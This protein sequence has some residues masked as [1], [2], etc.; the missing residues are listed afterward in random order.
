MSLTVTIEFIN[1]QVD[2]DG[3]PDLTLSWDEGE[4]YYNFAVNGVSV[5]SRD[6]DHTYSAPSGFGNIALANSITIEIPGDRS[7]P[8]SNFT[9]SGWVREW[10]GSFRFDDDYAGEFS[11]RY[12]WNN[13]YGTKD[14]ALSGATREKI[15][16]H[17]LTGDGIDVTVFW[18]ISVTYS[19]AGS[20][21]ATQPGMIGVRAFV[22]SNFNRDTGGGFG[23]RTRAQNFNVGEYPQLQTLVVIGTKLRQGI[24]P[25]AISSVLVGNGFYAELY[26]Q[27]N[28]G[29]RKLEI[30][31]N[32]AVMPG[33]WNDKTQSLR[34]MKL[35]IPG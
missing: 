7:D 28:F 12:D 6:S 23:L 1:I 18:K 13:E 27:P 26:D 25:N 21:K 33:D 31:Q 14:G 3:D 10:D 5:S 22:D 30:S 9:V 4:F 32:T 2:Q 29:G 11:Y 8:R 35:R 20:L 34:V 24:A 15:H 16:S 17:R 19:L